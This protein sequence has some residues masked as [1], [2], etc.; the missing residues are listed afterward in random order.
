M[1]TLY[2]SLFMNKMFYFLELLSS[3]NCLCSL[4]SQL[5]EECTIPLTPVWFSPALLDEMDK[6]VPS[7]LPGPGPAEYLAVPK[8]KPV[9]FIG[10]LSVSSSYLN[11]K[12]V[13][14][15]LC[16]CKNLTFPLFLFSSEALCGTKEGCCLQEESV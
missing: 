4:I 5:V 14:T 1:L 3:N 12:S 13:Q 9:I 16:R 15:T 6:V 8:G 7:H 10:F 11:L 2:L